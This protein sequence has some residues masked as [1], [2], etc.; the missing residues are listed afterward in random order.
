[1]ANNSN[2]IDNTTVDHAIIACSEQGSLVS[3]T[4]ALSSDMNMKAKQT[5][6][7]RE[8]GGAITTFDLQDLQGRQGGDDIDWLISCSDQESLVFLRS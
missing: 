4:G 6:I 1:M 5:L 2:N 7:Y 3:T 8:K